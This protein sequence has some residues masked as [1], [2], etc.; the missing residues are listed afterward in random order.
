MVNKTGNGWRLGRQ[1]G[2]ALVITAL[3]ACGPVRT[4]SNERFL[5]SG[6]LIA[7]SGGNA[8]AQNACFT[9][10]GVEGRGNGAGA[11]RL[12]GI[13]AGYLDRQLEAY[14]DGRRQHPQ[15]A[16]ISRQLSA[17]DRQ[18]VSHYYAALPWA[19]SEPVPAVQPPEL[20]VKGDPERALAP[21][22]ACH[23]VNGEGEG[24]ANPP[25]A[26]Q[27]AAYLAEQL[28]RWR[29]SQ[30]RTDPGQVMLQISQ[31]LTPS[32]ATILSSYASGLPG[33]KARP[34]Y[35]AA[36]LAA[37]RPVPGSDGSAPPRYAGE[38]ARAAR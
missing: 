27:P 24:Y 34:G 25:L 9:C 16:W 6:E 5:E 36:S 38:P 19:P 1:L 35:E 8:G 3:A 23:G 29:Y 13:G 7:W 2:G 12:A 31:R 32:E 33:A 11:P 14:D 22:A 21:C 18:A 17:A 4:T 28:E 30:R 37:R 15:M 10:H 26:G 20:W